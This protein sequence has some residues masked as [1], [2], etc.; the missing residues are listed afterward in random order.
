MK[1][2]GY[3]YTLAAN[4]PRNTDKGDLRV[5]FFRAISVLEG[6]SYLLILSVTLGFI[7]RDFVSTLGMAHG[8][9]FMLYLVLSL[10]VS[11]KQSWSLPVW[12]LVFMGSLVPFAFI[13]VELFLRKASSDN[14]ETAS[15]EP[16]Q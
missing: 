12:L 10:Q 14:V 6:L 3:A 7:S 13:A 5:K 1:R 2:P 11:H 8:V 4:P 15:P 9:L 16:A